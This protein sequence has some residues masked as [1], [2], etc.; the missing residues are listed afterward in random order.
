MSTA[1]AGSTATLL[2]ELAPQVLA[3]LARRHRDF[4]A[5]ED[6]LQQAL[7]AAA[8]QWPDT[9]VPQQP[10]AWL[11]RVASRRLADHV[12]AE[13][14]RTRR[15]GFV[16]DA[17]PVTA[18]APDDDAEVVAGSFEETLFTQQRLLDAV[19]NVTNWEEL[20]A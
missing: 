9:G 8:R 4:A 16:F 10:R 13:L 6:A 11:L 2:R 20:I 17:G 12:R 7:L 1:A 19:G 5:A 14:A 3:K 15:E 18:P